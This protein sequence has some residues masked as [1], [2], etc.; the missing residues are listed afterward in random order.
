MYLSYYPYSNENIEG[1]GAQYQRIIALLC[2]AKYHNLKY[3]HIPI[4]IGHNYDND[5][6]W[7]EK[8]DKMFNIKKFSNNNE[9]NINALDKEYNILLSLDK[10]KNPNILYCFHNPYDLF[11]SN[12]HEYLTNIQKELIKE[13]DENNNHR[14]LIY[15]KNKINIAIHIRVF[16][17]YDDNRE[18]NNFINNLSCRFIYTSDMYKKLINN[19]KQ[20]YPNSDIHIFSQNKYFDLKYK[21]LRYINYIQFHLDDMEHLDTFHHLCKADVLV[22]GLSSFSMLAGFYNNNTVIYLNYCTPPAL[23]SWIVY[24]N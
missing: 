7:N 24:D 17:D 15:N 12:S 10:L 21:S 16:N 20:N 2:I 6:L 5:P 14:K 1:I 19:L 9:I 18:Y 8:W 13:Y 11:Y 23:K 4:K 22:L 3:I